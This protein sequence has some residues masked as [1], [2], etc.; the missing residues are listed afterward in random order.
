VHMY[1]VK[2]ME[3]DPHFVRFFCY[4]GLF[5]FFMLFLVTG[6]NLASIFL[7]WEGVGLAS[8]LLINFWY[9][10][11]QAN[12]AAL[13]AVIVNRV[14]D[15]GIVLSIAGLF[16]LFKTIK[17]A[18][19]FSLIYIFNSYDI[20]I[21]NTSFNVLNL[22][23]LSLF[24]GAASKSAQ[25]GL[26]T[27]LPDAM[28]GPTPVSALIHAATMVTAGVFVLI[29][30]SPIFEYSFDILVIVSTLGC[31]TAFFAGTIGLFQYDLKRVIAYS[32]CSQL[33]YMVMACGLSSYSASMFHLMT[34]AFF[35]ALLFLGAGAVIHG[36][37]DEQDMR[38]MGGLLKIMPFTY[39][40]MF[41][42]SFSLMGFPFTSGY[43]SKDFI[44]ELAQSQ[45]FFDGLFC[46][47]LGVLGAGFTA[48]YSIRALFMTFFVET[49]SFKKIINEVHEVPFY[50]GVPLFILAF[51]SI[52]IGYI[53]KETFLG[54]G[55][56]TWDNSLLIS[57]LEA[58]KHL[59]EG[60]YLTASIRM[61]PVIVSIFGS[62]LGYFMYYYY[63]KFFFKFFIKNYG[64]N[65]LYKFFIK[66]W[67]F[68]ILYN[69][70][71]VLNSMLVGNDI[72][73]KKYDRGVLEIIGPSG[74][75]RFIKNC[76]GV[77]TRLQSGYI[78]HYLLIMVLG[79]ILLTTMFLLDINI[80]INMNL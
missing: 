42:G 45:L 22:I 41:I 34:H 35:K 76:M 74:L 7:G 15:I 61:F 57:D 72:F 2:Y 17:I 8:Y 6:D 5:T 71:I 12:K 63:E 11:T 67:L 21:G 49:K 53:S 16:Y 24:L 13:K 23:C 46:Y 32:T 14:G 18:P 27:W 70:Y 58:T 77:V 19:I 51:F 68:D 30:F 20:L 40:V 75:V 31:I 36:M 10:R 33:G 62:I 55:V 64:S 65:V 9:T 52:F 43:Y 73:Y 3:G 37:H 39:I 28:E 47:I 69:R 38:R 50:M 79:I 1:S 48:Y 25:C 60:E 54:V 66:K 44:L 80:N 26:H 4:L 29:R 59:I 78:F 56:I